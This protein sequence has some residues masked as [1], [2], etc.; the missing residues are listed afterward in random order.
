MG[1]G[2]D[3]FRVKARGGGG[4]GEYIVCREFKNSWL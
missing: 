3:L 4:G 2:T 1:Y